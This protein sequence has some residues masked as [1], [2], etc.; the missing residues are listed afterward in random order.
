MVDIFDFLAKASQ[1]PSR[2]IGKNVPK[3]SKD[4]LSQLNILNQSQLIITGDH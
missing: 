1:I 2:K 4:Q 3:L